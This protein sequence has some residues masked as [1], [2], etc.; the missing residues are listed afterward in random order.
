MI[1][2]LFKNALLRDRKGEDIETQKKA[3]RGKKQKLDL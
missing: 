3:T 2:G 1:Y